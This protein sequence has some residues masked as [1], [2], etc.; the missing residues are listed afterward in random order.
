MLIGFQGRNLSPNDITHIKNI[1][2][3]GIVFYRR[4]FRDATDV[5]HL[6]SRINSFLKQNKL[7]MF[8]AIDQEGGIV[9]RLE[10]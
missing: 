5:S 3:G 7:P 9:H 4:N 6:I 1:R 10:G 8:F 2:P